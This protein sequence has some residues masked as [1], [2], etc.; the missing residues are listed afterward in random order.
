MKCESQGANSSIPIIK[1]WFINGGWG[2]KVD[3]FWNNMSS[4]SGKWSSLDVPGKEHS[5]ERE[6][7]H[8]RAMKS[9][10]MERFLPNILWK[11]C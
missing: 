1:K 2:E 9:K 7:L 4:T 6:M 8:A 3:N 5:E 10:N 11:S